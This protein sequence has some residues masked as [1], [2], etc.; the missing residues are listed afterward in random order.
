MAT[1]I[2]GYMRGMKSWLLSGDRGFALEK[3]SVRQDDSG[4]EVVW[5]EIEEVERLELHLDG[6][7]GNRFIGWGRSTSEALPEG[8]TLDED[9]GVFYWMPSPGFLGK[10]VLHFAVTDGQIRGRPV[11]IVVDIHPKNY[12][13]H[14]YRHIKKLKK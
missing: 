5:I 7:G 9:N 4:A 2:E 11:K 8:S 6:E 10:H 14:P 12:P 1:G 3:P 13:R